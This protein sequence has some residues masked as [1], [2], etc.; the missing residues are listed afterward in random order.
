[1]WGD[2]LVGV[3]ESQTGMVVGLA[4]SDTDGAL[5]RVGA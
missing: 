3:G 1:M 4:G 2:G 5:R